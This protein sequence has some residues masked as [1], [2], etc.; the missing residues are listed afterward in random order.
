MALSARDSRAGFPT[1]LQCLGTFL[2]RFLL[3]LELCGL[4][5]Q[6]L[7]LLLG[8]L[9]LPWRSGSALLVCSLVGLDLRLQ[10]GARGIER[11]TL[12]EHYLTPLVAPLDDLDFQWLRQ[13]MKRSPV[14]FSMKVCASG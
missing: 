10:T 12:L 9:L 2:Y 5:T 14:E 3:L 8:V 7:A 13:A 1:L 6:G 11:G 4:F